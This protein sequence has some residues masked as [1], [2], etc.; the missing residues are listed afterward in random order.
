MGEL[1]ESA[2][3]GMLATLDPH[4]VYIEPDNSE[5]IQESFDGKFQGIGIQF[6][7]I[8]DTITVITPIS[9]G[10]SDQL[11]IM[12]G[13]RIISINDSSAIG[14]DNQDVVSRLRGEK[15]TE[16]TIQIKRPNRN[17]PLTFNIIRDDIPITTLDTQYMLDDRT[18]YI[19]INR[20]QLPLTMSF[21]LL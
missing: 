6:N 12:S 2:I 13:D 11:G 20:L 19:K 9:G 17:N 5:R 4:S 15:G 1:T 7:I 16:V 10:P 3:R 8:Q 14:Y 21:L 18:G